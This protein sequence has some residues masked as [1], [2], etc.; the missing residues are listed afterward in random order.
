[1]CDCF[2]T[3]VGQILKIWAPK[4]ANVGMDL[5]ILDITADYLEKEV[6]DRNLDLGKGKLL[7]VDGKDWL[8]VT[9]GNDNA[10]AKETFSSKNEADAFR[11]LTFSTAS[12]LVCESSPLFGGRAGER[13]IV[14]FMGSLGPETANVKEWE[15]VA[16]RDPWKP[17]DDTFWT[18]LSDVVSADE[19][20]K[21]MSQVDDG[22]PMVTGGVIDD[23]VLVTGQQT[24]LAREGIGMGDE[25]SDESKSP[26]A[27]C[28]SARHIFSLDDAIGSFDEMSKHRRVDGE[29]QA[30]GSRKRAPILT[31]DILTEQ[32]EKAIR[33]DPNFSG[34]T[35]L[36]QLERHQRLHLLYEAGKLRKCLLSYF[37]KVVTN[38][39]IKLLRWMGSP[40][41]SRVPK[42]SITD[43]PAIPLRLAKLP[44]DYGMCGDKGFTNIEVYLPNVNIVDT[45]PAVVNSKTHRLSAEMIASEI[46]VTTVRAPCETVFARVQD[47]AIMTERVPY[48]RLP[49]INHGHMLALGEAKL[50]QL[51]R[52]PGR[53]AI[54]GDDYWSNKKQYTTTIER[55]TRTEIDVGRSN[56][57]LCTSCRRGGIVLFCSQ[58]KNWYH[59]E[60]DCHNFDA[61]SG[62]GVR[63]PYVN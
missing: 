30:S 13:K 47:E 42:P 4:W 23:G 26:I 34:K 19:Y 15:D 41:A 62:G 56:R 29:L 32:N 14:E 55:A 7:F 35:K 21:M 44:P 17:E 8:M 9:K 48:H 33:N 20:D 40:L 45:P 57:R 63:N 39:R 6:P 12:G 24:G 16:S 59:T 22:A 43:L 53:N 3:R 46:P 36:R 10:L 50:C 38:D 5:A 2:S 18:A 27:E 28:D 61:C 54:V 49:F 58:C 52:K 31:A 11:G 25:S 60:G 37:L 1:M 51:L